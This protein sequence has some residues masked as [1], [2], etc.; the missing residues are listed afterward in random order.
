MESSVSSV[1]P[2][3]NANPIIFCG[4]GPGDPDLITVKGQQ[5]LSHA[6]LVV[7]AGSLVPEALLKWTRPAAAT[8]VARACTWMKWSP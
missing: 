1:S 7:Y 2:Q 6:D 5:A 3:S 8:K 4:A